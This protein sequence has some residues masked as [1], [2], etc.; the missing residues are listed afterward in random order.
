[1]FQGLVVLK[2]DNFDLSRNLLWFF[3]KIVHTDH[4]CP[5]SPAR[6][7]CITSAY[8]VFRAESHS[9]LGTTYPGVKTSYTKKTK[10][11]KVIQQIRHARHE[12]L[13]NSSRSFIKS[14]SNEIRVAG[15]RAIFFP[16]VIY[17]WLV[18]SEFRFATW[19]NQFINV[20]ASSSAAYFFSM[21]FVTF[22]TTADVLK[23]STRIPR[24]QEQWLKIEFVSCGQYIFFTYFSCSVVYF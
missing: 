3:C 21:H 6:Y 23:W 10:T 13:V 24:P 19:G 15:L 7:H 22:P 12:K 1:M 4:I 11:L 18:I 16:V 8:Q 20:G 17:F 5:L 2:F 9:F 14:N